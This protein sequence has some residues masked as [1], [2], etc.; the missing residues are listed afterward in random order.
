MQIDIH[1]EILE[2]SPELRLGHL[3]ATVEIAPSPDAFWEMA[4]ALLQSKASLSADDIR[5]QPVIAASRA[6]YKALG[7]DP[8]RYRLSAEALHRRLMKEQGLYHLANVVDII[9]VVSLQTGYSIGGYDYDEVDFPVQ[10]RKGLAEDP[11]KSIGRGSLNIANLPVLEDGRG[12]FGNPTSDSARTAIR[13]DSK[14]VW[15]VFFAFGGDE[16]GELESTLEQTCRW[17]EQYAG[18]RQVEYDVQYFD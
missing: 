7:Q 15:L 6:V 18:A 1:P 13:P 16:P 11:Y 10:L 8:S 9:N 2:A 4:N 5:H 12:P 3:L 17:L 14:H